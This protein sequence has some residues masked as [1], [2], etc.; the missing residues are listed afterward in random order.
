MGVIGIM[1]CGPSVKESYGRY[2]KHIQKYQNCLAHRC[3]AFN[4]SDLHTSDVK[5]LLHFTFQGPIIIPDEN[6]A[7]YLNTMISDFT[8][9]LISSMETLAG[10]KGR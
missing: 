7:F 8:C 6:L 9:E 1:T 4:P 2:T 5:V 10:K 3:F